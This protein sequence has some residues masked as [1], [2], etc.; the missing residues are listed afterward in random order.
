MFALHAPSGHPRIINGNEINNRS[1][2]KALVRQAQT[3]SSQI[4]SSPSTSAISYLSAMASSTDSQSLALLASRLAALESSSNANTNA[5][6]FAETKATDEQLKS[7]IA[8][9]IKTAEDEKRKQ[10]LE[11]AI[12][13]SIKTAED[14]KKQNFLVRSELKYQTDLSTAIAL[15]LS[16]P[17][18]YFSASSTIT[19]FTSSPSTSTSAS[20]SITSFSSSPSTST[21]ASSS[22][23]SLSSS[24]STSTSSSSLS[25]SF[26]AIITGNAPAH[27]TKCN[28]INN[29]R[30]EW[31]NRANI[32][33]M[34]SQ[35]YQLLTQLD[36]LE[37][38]QM[39]STMS[40][41]NQLLDISS[42]NVSTNLR[43]EWLGRAKTIKKDLRRQ[44]IRC[45]TSE[46]LDIITKVP[47]LQKILDM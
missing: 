1:I 42:N 41:L 43:V 31:L 40:E 12:A 34:S 11:T 35:L 27:F 9:S 46:F 44:L 36:T 29:L 10:D 25:S 21:S 15:S 13:Q 16:Q 7:A 26:P 28:T 32:M 20:S 22:L 47:E 5:T 6:S 38:L 37:F 45:D 23:T 2:Y 3:N 4:V 8:Q 24:P 14:E 19:T 18:L 17:T 33:Q 30:V 39:A